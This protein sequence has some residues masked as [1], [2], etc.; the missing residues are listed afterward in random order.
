MTGASMAGR[1]HLR[2]LARI[3]S[4]LGHKD[5]RLVVGDDGSCRLLSRSGGAALA[6]ERRL[7]AELVSAGLVDLEDKLLHVTRAGQAALVRWQEGAPDY[8]AQHRPL[9]RLPNGARHDDAESPLAWLA[10]R[11]DRDGR[12]FL[13]AYEVEAGERLRRDFTQ[14]G[15]TRSICMSWNF[16]VVPGKG[17]RGP[18]DAHEIADMALDARKRVQ[19]ALSALEPTLRGLVLDVCCF[20]KGLE[21]VERERRWPRRSAKLVLRIALSQLAGHYGMLPPQ[22]SAGVR[23]WGTSD[24]RPG[25]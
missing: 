7:L 25:A 5:L 20:L 9:S 24:Y 6:I 22:H 17:R 1:R 23:H 8:L 4:R 21:E 13:A 10:T 16:A 19:R 11:R 18:A 3:K 12:P 15:L 2:L 14:A